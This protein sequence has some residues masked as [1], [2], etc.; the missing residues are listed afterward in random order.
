MDDPTERKTWVAPLG[1]STKKPAGEHAALI[2]IK[3]PEPPR[4]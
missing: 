2:R 4:S 1:M 3:L